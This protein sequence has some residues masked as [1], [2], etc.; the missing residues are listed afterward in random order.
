MHPDDGTHADDPWSASTQ[1]LYPSETVEGAV[2]SSA[3]DEAFD[4]DAAPI[5]DGMSPASYPDL[6]IDRF[7][8]ARDRLPRLRD[9]V[10][11]RDWG[12]RDERA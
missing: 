11:G 5:A 3:R 12:D 4:L 10:V 6:I 8:A 7:D 1:T 9:K 2:A